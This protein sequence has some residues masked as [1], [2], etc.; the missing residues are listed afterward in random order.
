MLLWKYNKGKYILKFIGVMN[1]SEFLLDTN[2]IILLWKQHPFVIDRLIE[3]DK[4]KILR[5]VSQELIS[6]KWKDY[7][8]EGILSERFCKLLKCIIQVDERNIKEFYRMLDLKYSSQDDSY[9]DNTEKLSENDLL[10]LYACYLDEKFILVTEDRYLYK[11]AKYILGS[12]R[13][14]TVNMLV[15]N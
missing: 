13:V 9:F 5:E 8:K 11:T 7:K 12:D 10:L 2:V 3:E 1:M 15:D 4:L 6:R 14:I